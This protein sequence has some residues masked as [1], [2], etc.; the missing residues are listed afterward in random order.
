LPTLI[1]Y[2][3]FVHFSSGC[4]IG[5]FIEYKDFINWIYLTGHYKDMPRGDLSTVWPSLKRFFAGCACITLHLVLVVYF[6]YSVYFCGKPEF[7]HH[8]TLLYRL[9]FMS[10]AMTSQRFMYYTP[11]C[12]SD[13]SLIA[14]GLAYNKVEK[15]KA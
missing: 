7:E 12:F 4:I 1:E 2:M 9:F 3:G 8:K 10:M 6:G 11:W 15:G 5:P 13:S 14:C